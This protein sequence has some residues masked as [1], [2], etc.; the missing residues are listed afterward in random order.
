MLE[1]GQLFLQDLDDNLRIGFIRAS[2]EHVVSRDLDGL[3]AGCFGLDCFHDPCDVRLGNPGTEDD[4]SRY[5][6]FRQWC[7]RVAAQPRC[8][9][10]GEL[11]GG[12]ERELC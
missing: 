6:S 7:A 3:H 4:G 5:L 8:G 12:D 1:S 2:A 9:L 11:A 10:R